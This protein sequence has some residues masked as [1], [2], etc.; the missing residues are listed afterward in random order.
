MNQLCC[1]LNPEYL[2]KECG[3]RVCQTCFGIGAGPHEQNKKYIHEV[4]WHEENNQCPEG[5]NVWLNKGGINV[6]N[7]RPLIFGKID[8]AKPE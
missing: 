1:K 2:C 3:M 5:A 7:E 8:N 4:A 6:A